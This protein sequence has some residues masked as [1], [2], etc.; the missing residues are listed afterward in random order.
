MVFDSDR[1]RD[2]DIVPEGVDVSEFDAFDRV[3]PRPVAEAEP[4][5]ER[6][7]VTDALPLLLP[8]ILTS[9]VAVFP[10]MDPLEVIDGDASLESDG[11]AEDDRDADDSRDD[12]MVIERSRVRD[13]ETDALKDSDSSCD[14]EGD[15]E[16]ESI[17]VSL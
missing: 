13:V 15:G 2:C 17:G 1:S 16:N 10:V 5:E 12:E 4:S 14:D 7:S 11:D 9:R 6:E 3:Q 8:D